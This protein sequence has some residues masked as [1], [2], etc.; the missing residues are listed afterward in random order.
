MIASLLQGL[1][2]IL[3]PRVCHACLQTLGSREDT[4]C[5]Q[6][7]LDLPRTNVHH[8]DFNIIHQ[9][10]GHECHVDRAAGWF[11]YRKDTPYAQMLVSAKYSNLPGLCVRLGA[12]CAT[13]LGKDGFFDGIDAIVPMT[14]HWAK[15][16]RR[17]YNQAYEICVGISKVTG[18]PIH[19]VLRAVRGHGVQ[20]RHTKQQRYTM[21][22][23][24]MDV[25]DPDAL[26]G[27]HIL[28]VD[29]IIT[30]GASMAEAVRTLQ[31]CAA[32]A[33]ISVLCLGL[34]QLS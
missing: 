23:N 14:M 16:M 2:H 13:E 25:R 33:S 17:G 6:C 24:S 11:Y 7:M 21:I 28:V 26:A 5:L 34:T 29:D 19:D 18:M 10:L 12:M 1:G 4:L 30:T 31:R 22:A 9:R 20:S 8:S 15:R 27:R 3:A 32:P